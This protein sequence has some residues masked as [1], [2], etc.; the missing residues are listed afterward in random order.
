MPNNPISILHITPYYTPAIAFGGVVSA[1]TGLAQAQV[2][3]G[4]QVTVLT[5]DALTF[6]SR[7]HTLRETIN[8]VNVIRCRNMSHMIRAKFNLSQPPSLWSEFRRIIRDVDVVHTHELRTVENLLI[9]RQRPIVLSPH[10]TLPYGTGRSGFKRGWDRVFG[11]GLLRKISAV[12]ALTASE[13]DDVSDVWSALNMPVLPIEI[14]PN[15]VAADFA[16]SV[17]MIVDQSKAQQFRERYKLG[18]GLVVLFL[19]R[20]HERKGLQYLIPAFAQIADKYPDARLLVVGP[21]EGMLGTAQSLVTQHHITN[22]V[23]FTGLLQGEDQRAAWA[24]ANLYVLP[25]VGEGLSMAALEAMAAGL[26]IIV[27]PGCN[28]PEVEQRGAGLLVGQEVEAISAALNMLMESESRRKLMGEA[29]QAWVRESFTWP[30]VAD[31]AEA[32]YRRIM[33]S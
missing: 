16:A 6:T 14:I 13:A 7:N 31:R 22:R 15:G 30:A 10:G 21:D 25:A 32:L 2:E 17:K 4:H 20:L 9:G 18:S 12:A 24:A 3:Q 23:T 1:V 26:P 33:R 27:T 29:G 19:G 11:R 5:T 28:L 8:G